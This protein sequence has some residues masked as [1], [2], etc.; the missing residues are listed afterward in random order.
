MENN[1]SIYLDGNKVIEDYFIDERSYYLQRFGKLPNVDFYSKINGERLFKELKD[2]CG[3]E[4]VAI[5]QRKWF[6][7]KKKKM[8]FD[9]MIVEM[10]G[11]M[12]LELR[13]NSAFLL[14]NGVES[15]N[16]LELRHFL[17]KYRI[18]QKKDPKEISLIVK[19]GNGLCLKNME[20]KNAKLDIDLYYNDDFAPIDNL[21]RNRLNKTDDKGIVLLHGLPGTGKTTYLRYLV[22]KV[23]KKVMFISPSVAGEMTNPDLIELLIDNPNSLLIVEDAENIVM[24]RRYNSSSSVST[25]LNISDGLLSDFLN[26]QLICT[27][28]SELAHIDEALMRKG[29]LIAHYEFGKLSVKKSKRLAQH[30]KQ[31]LNISQPMSLAEITNANVSSN[32]RVQGS[33]IGFRRLDELMETQKHEMIMA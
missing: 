29:R 2:K 4:I 22:S 23:K 3:E 1:N 18:R 7:H 30:L 17:L 28:N 31:D 16:V 14:Y 19:D 20:V 8:R 12:V 26:V 25:L 6:D 9:R 24:N 27:F 13:E 11:G 10:K 33:R 21:I 15:G 5:Y 32:E